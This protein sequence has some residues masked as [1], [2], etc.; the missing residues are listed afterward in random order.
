ME[1]EKKLKKA[2]K[3]LSKSKI[4]NKIS[5][6]FFIHEAVDSSHMLTFSEFA[7]DMEVWTNYSNSPKKIQITDVG[8][9][10]FE[11]G[12]YVDPRYGIH[13][14]SRF[15][16]IIENS[17]CQH[18]SIALQSL[19]AC[20]YYRGRTV[21]NLDKKSLKFCVS[22]AGEWTSNYFHWVSDWLTRFNYIYAD[23]EMLQHRITLIAPAELKSFQLEYL[24]ELLPSRWTIYKPDRHEILHV[25]RLAIYSVPTKQNIHLPNSYQFDSTAYIPA[26]YEIVNEK[27][28]NII[29]TESREFI[30]LI[31]RESQ[32]SRQINNS[33]VLIKTLRSEFPNQIVVTAYLEYLPLKVQIGLFK[34]A[35]VIV[36]AH[37]AGLTNIIFCE[38]CKIIEIVPRSARTAYNPLAYHF[39]NQ[40]SLVVGEADDN[41]I[42]LQ[43]SQINE[44]AHQIHRF[45]FM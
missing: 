6:Y 17:G 37:G 22:F 3:F 24:R 5:N 15:K 42:F 13:L 1:I 33:E 35:D 4:I 36:G 21:R 25:E 34:R 8:Y 11:W 12:C 32:D 40:Y 45:L 39:N 7:G 18:I 20:L 31:Q 10:F 43:N 19:F 14:T 23:K 41:Q 30:L 2:G 27:F 44:I 28:K 16:I 29:T 9:R 26:S 38:S